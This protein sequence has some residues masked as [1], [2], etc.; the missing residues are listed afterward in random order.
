MDCNKIS[1][2]IFFYGWTNTV[3]LAS[4]CNI[5]CSSPLIILVALSTGLAPPFLASRAVTQTSCVEEV[6]PVKGLCLSRH[7]AALR[8][9]GT[10]LS[11]ME[12]LQGSCSAQLLLHSPWGGFNVCHE[13]YCCE[14]TWYYIVLYFDL[15]ETYC[16]MLKSQHKPDIA[17]AIYTWITM[18]KWFPLLIY[19]CLLSGWWASPVHQEGICG[20]KPSQAYCSRDLLLL[21][22][23]FYTFCGIEPRHVR[24]FS[25]C[26]PG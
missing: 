4:P 19:I 12:A 7:P 9:D 11:G 25:P 24:T 8:R 15:V 10:P 17:V 20:L 2:F 5:T 13:I 6:V 18:Q 14:D 16:N 23:R 21:V 1:L 3:F 22:F 26:W